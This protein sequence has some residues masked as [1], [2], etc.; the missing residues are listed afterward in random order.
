MTTVLIAF[1]TVFIEM[2]TVFI[3]YD[4]RPHGDKVP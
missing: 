3:G 1:A 4:D 2:A